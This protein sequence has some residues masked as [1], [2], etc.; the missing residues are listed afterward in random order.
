MALFNTSRFNKLL[1][2]VKRGFQ[3]LAS[4]FS[5]DFWKQ[6]TE[7]EIAKSANPGKV[8]VDW[9]YKTYQNNPEK[10]VK[11]RI[12][13]PG[14]LVIYDYNDPI[15]KDT[16]KYWDMNPL[17]LV[18]QPFITKKQVIR[19][20]GINLHLLPKNI[21]MLVLYQCFL[22]YKNEYTSQLFTDKEATQINISW[23]VIKKQLEKYGAGFA[24][25]MYD[26]ERM[27]NVIEFNQD[28]WKYAIH[29][30]SRKYNKTNII[31][32][33]K[34]WKEYIKNKG[35]KVQTAGESHLK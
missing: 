31:E 1:N 16:L 5:Y 20:M 18:M 25:R 29:I 22:I 8:A 24:I 23:R 30:P 13:K 19:S 35:K 28:D 33:E 10:Y 21:R 15:H 32:L 9:Y 4:K 7:N 2:S 6:M 17:V 11:R 27:T 14:T 12:I 34:M 26:N 3:K